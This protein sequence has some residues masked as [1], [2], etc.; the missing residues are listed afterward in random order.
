MLRTVYH[1]F[2]WKKTIFDIWGVFVR[3]LPILEIEAELYFI[4]KRR[5]IKPSMSKLLEW[6]AS[7]VN[8]GLELLSIFNP[9]DRQNYRVLCIDR[10]VYSRNDVVL[11]LQPAL[12]QLKL[13]R[14]QKSDLVNLCYEHGAIIVLNCSYMYFFTSQTHGSF[15]DN[16]FISGINLVNATKNQFVAGIRFELT[17][18]QV[19][20]N[21][22]N[23]LSPHP[24]FNN[25]WGEF[26]INNF[27]PLIV[28]RWDELN[29]LTLKI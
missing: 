8:F 14:D 26:L 2:T 19:S 5:T 4:K 7:S 24:K 15:G 21:L 20:R 3:V 1:F 17:D 27:V 18:S 22:V 11:L 23:I 25:T 10:N 28:E 12:N 16:F 29:G 9:N 6:L 13:N